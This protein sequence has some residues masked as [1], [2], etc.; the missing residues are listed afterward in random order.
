M[1]NSFERKSRRSTK[2]R[3]AVSRRDLLKGAASVA[4]G[5]MAGV[6]GARAQYSGLTPGGGEV[7][8]RLPSGAMNYL[9]RNEYIHNMEIVSHLSGPSVDSGEP[10]MAMWARGGGCPAGC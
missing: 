2:A 1:S 6:T 9:D 4:L 3:G 7:P 8:F 10:L 5:S